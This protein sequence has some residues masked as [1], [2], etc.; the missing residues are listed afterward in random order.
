[1]CTRRGRADDSATAI[2]LGAYHT[3]V[4]VIGGSVKCW[5]YNG[6]GQLGTGTFADHVEPVDVELESG[7][8]VCV[9]V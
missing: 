3:C 6:Y 1:M 4:L 2:A 9:C 5:G 8:R 7:A